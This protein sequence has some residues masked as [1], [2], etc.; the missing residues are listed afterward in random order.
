ME[1]QKIVKKKMLTPKPYFLN[2]PQLLSKGDMI[3]DQY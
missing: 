1:K 2:S 3:W